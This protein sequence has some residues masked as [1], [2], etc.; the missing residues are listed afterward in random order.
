VALD[1]DTAGELGRYVNGLEEHLVAVRQE[2]RRVRG[3][4]LLENI[5]A[6]MLAALTAEEQAALEPFLQRKNLAE[7][8]AQR[9]LLIAQ[10]DA[11]VKAIL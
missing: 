7:L 3:E 4:I 6:E 2:L 1:Q 5:E 11:L 8:Q 9:Q 10:R